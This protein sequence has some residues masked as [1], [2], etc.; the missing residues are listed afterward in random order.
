MTVQQYFEKI[1]KRFQSGIS[2]EHSY[3][4]DLQLLLE[5]LCTEA[6]VTNEPIRIA[7]GAPDY[8]LTRQGNSN[9]P[10]GYIEA[11]DLTEGLNLDLIEQSEQLVRYRN[12]LNNLILT[13]Y[14]R[15]RFYLNKDRVTDISIAKISNGKLIPLSENW[16]AFETL[17]RDFSKYT[18][19]TIR[20][21]LKLAEMMASKARVMQQVLQTALESDE[22]SQDNS[23]LKDQLYAFKNILIHDI[24]PDEFADI[25]AQTIAYGL[26]AARLHDPSIDTFSRQEA[27][28]LIPK[29]NPFLKKLFGYIAGV[30]IDDRIVWIVDALAEVFRAADVSSILK[31][32]GK[33]T[34]M[35][36]PLIHFYETFLAAYN[37]KLRKSRGVWYT[38]E[39]VVNFI[40]RSVDEILKKEFGLSM[41]L[42]DSSKIKIKRKH[43]TK[44]TADKRSKIKD[45][46]LEEEVHKV[47]ILDPATG[48]GTFLAEVIRLIYSRF[49]DQK[50]IWSQYAEEHLIPRIHGFE[51]LMASY[52]MAH[53]KLDLLLKETGYKASQKEK[54]LRIYLTNSLEEAHPDTK[55]L[56]A[57]WLSQEATEANTL[58]RETP[59]M[60]VI[61]NPPYSV[62]SSNKGEWIEN[63]VSDYKKGLKEKNIN[64]L[65]DDYIKFIRYAQYFIQKNGQGIVA[66]ITNNSFVDGVIHRQMRKSLVE[67]FDKIYIWDLHGNSKKKEVAIDGLKDENVFD[68]QQGVS[69]NVFIKKAHST[70]ETKLY[71][72]DIL[73]SRKSKYQS[74]I[75]TSI[76]DTKW[77]ELEIVEP[78]Y[79]F[80]KKDF[81]ESNEYEKGFKINQLF[82]IY[83]TGIKSHRDDFVTAFSKRELES[84][85]LKYFD[86]SISDGELMS[87]YNLKDTGSWKLSTSRSGKFDESLML[88]FYY[89]PFDTRYIY[90]SSQ[91]VERPRI[92][93][94]KNFLSINNLGLILPK[95]NTENIGALV[96]ESLPG[97]KS[98]AA[99]DINSVFPLYI[100]NDNELK[101]GPS[102]EPNL[103]Q[104]IVSQIAGITGL[105]FHV[106]KDLFAKGGEGFITP[107]DILDYIYAVLY[108]PQYKRKYNE[109]LKIDYPRIPYP[110]NSTAFQRLSLLGSKLR[111][112]H[113]LHSKNSESNISYPISGS[114]RVEKIR[115]EKFNGEVGKIFI[116]KTQYFENIS[117]KIWEMY[118]GGYMPAQK[119]LKD[120]KD[121]VLNYEEVIHYQGIINTLM[122]TSKLVDEL[123]LL[124]IS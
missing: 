8:I 22:I 25:Y 43:V 90:Y 119:W 82:P 20:S 80:T 1:N 107:I 12:S 120:R 45:I 114:N 52:A 21:A 76:Y 39:P 79:F 16:P 95:Q 106:L 11:K 63:L 56:F 47:Q 44:A 118:V 17:I 53:L 18:G 30:E 10:I 71:Q 50:G 24:K 14:I 19:I 68:I 57:S 34:K 6:D 62:S 58:K 65:S 96:S 110:K 42:A 67:A 84:R 108:H 38:P 123:D 92:E 2:T 94:L 48:T 85:L 3:R 5:S 81:S 46:E 13:D 87:T 55:T 99:Y 112:S 97:H 29:S 101:F 59:V 41:G 31:N 69:I 37:P 40:V 51:L 103:N 78:Y 4:S 61:G 109:F 60:V 124:E 116:N 72:K 36:D 104:K 115:F 113:L 121:R 66:M 32:F 102:V 88:P 64:P 93:V 54:R 33:A 89:R 100:N 91:I 49:E 83:T 35:E 27:A 28:E 117:N 77:N 98:Y 70:E 111:L 23:S 74:L 26:F 122:E 75:N 86:S 9:F 73:G 105:K 15:F 7:C